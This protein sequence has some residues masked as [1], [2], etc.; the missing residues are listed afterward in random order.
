MEP[1][2]VIDWTKPFRLRGGNEVRI[3]NGDSGGPKPVHGAY[4][5]G[6]EWIPASWTLTGSYNL[7][8]NS[9]LDIINV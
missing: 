8:N 5:A 2:L 4:K 9:A 7:D 6:D 3:Y 1:K